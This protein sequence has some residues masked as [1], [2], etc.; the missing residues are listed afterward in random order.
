MV[1]AAGL[2][3]SD[4]HFMHG[5]A[6]IALPVVLGHDGAGTV[7]KV[8]PGVTSVQQGQQVHLSC[9]PAT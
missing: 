5:D 2:C 7:D 3:R 4:R 8:G 1:G 6:P 9:V